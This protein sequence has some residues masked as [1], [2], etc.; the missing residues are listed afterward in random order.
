MILKFFF[1]LRILTA[2]FSKP[3]ARI[4]SRK[5][6]FISSA[7]FVL[8]LKLHAITPPKAL[9]GQMHMHFKRS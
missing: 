6:L 1:F 5:F 7:I 4:T 3:F 9:M 2:F 8:I